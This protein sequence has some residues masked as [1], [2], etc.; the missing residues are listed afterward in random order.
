M[1]F[2]QLKKICSLV[3]AEK[4]NLSKQKYKFIPAGITTDSRKIN[5]GELF[6]ALNGRYAN[7]N[8][9]MLQSL[10]AGASACIGSLNYLSNHP[11]LEAVPDLIF[12]TDP[13]ESLGLIG[14]QR[15][16]KY[17]GKVIAVTGSNG[18]TVVKEMLGRV[19]RDQC[20]TSPGSYNS[21]LGVPLSIVQMDSTSKIWILEAGISSKGEMSYLEEIIQPD[22]GI[23]TNIGL[24]HFAGFGRQ[25]EIAREKLKLFQNIGKD[26]WILLPGNSSLIKTAFKN[27]TF[28]AP[29]FFTGESD[30]L[31]HI[32]DR[33]VH[34]YGFKLKIRFPNREIY[35]FQAET[36]A[37]P[38]VDDLEISAGVAY[39]MGFSPEMIVNQLHNYKSGETRM[40]IWNS[41][42]GI[43]L[44][45]DTC[46]SDPISV[47]GALRSM[48]NFPSE[49]GSRHFI[50]AGMRELGSRK[51]DEHFHIG[52]LAAEHKVEKL[53]MPPGKL[54]D[55]TAN[56]FRNANPKGIVRR[57][58]NEG[59]LME[60]LL[61]RS[62]QG[63]IILFKGP[64]NAN[65]SEIAHQVFETMA[66][67]RYV[68]DFEMIN[69]NIRTFKKLTGSEVKILA[70]VKALAYGS[71]MNRLAVELEKTT[72]DFLGVSTPDEGIQLR[73]SGAR[74][75]ILVMITTSEEIQKLYNYNL[76][77]VITSFDLLE[78]I[79]KS[80]E[81]RKKPTSVHIKI[82]TGMG[83]LGI[84]YRDFEKLIEYLDKW[85]MIKVSGLMTHFGCADDPTEDLLTRTQIDRF[86]S[87]KHKLALVLEQPFT[88][89]AAATSSVVRFKESHFDMIRVGLG[90][91]GI[92]PSIQVQR[93]INLGLA[94][95]FIT[96]II[97]LRILNKGTRIGYGGT[98]EIP[99][100][101]FKIAVLPLGYN[102]GLPWR[103][104]N[105]GE[106]VIN[107]CR[108]PIVGRI[109]MDSTLVDVNNVPEVKKGNNVLIF[110]RMDGHEQ[111]PEKLA[112]TAGT[113]V[114]E[115]LTGIGNR[116][117]RIYQGL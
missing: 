79:G 64:R 104:S 76:T 28:K 83:R 14:K 27:Y 31:P 100:D 77:A 40:E 1:Y 114:Y 20:D 84:S 52:E 91:Y 89:H 18:K 24:A 51:L 94:V 34:E 90:L 71:E 5:P 60:F 87:F 57:Y 109:S 97:D 61:E 65:I 48:G 93:E 38:I 15:R 92:H 68:V 50:F 117:Q 58:S 43:T 21:R 46:S 103:L 110:G 10:E 19:F 107:G 85:K 44:I 8:D 25:E 41:P 73:E 35:N 9:Y 4:C 53:L 101:N 75:P 37:N 16:N 11:E 13:L 6:I 54:L 17:Q 102:D 22:Y 56:G 59:E 113:I 62:T 69:E 82:D 36:L 72:V 12:T 23:L 98:Y 111:R 26:G 66:P 32:I 78:T 67:N 115:I 108:A 42:R 49:T 96:R 39:L 29:V 106:V 81:K 88:A 30:N 45:N 80:A 33:K 2:P 7:G 116:V 70:M 105:R 74:L 63:D 112:S 3:S 55:A 47:E 86:K 99:Y 95:S